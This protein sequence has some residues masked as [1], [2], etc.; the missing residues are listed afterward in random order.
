MG[1]SHMNLR[2][3]TCFSPCWRALIFW[4]FCNKWQRLLSDI[5]RV[6]TILRS[7]KFW[8]LRIWKYFSLSWR[9]L[10]FGIFLRVNGKRLLNDICRVLTVPP[11]SIFWSLC[12]DIQE[13][14]SLQLPLSLGSSSLHPEISNRFTEVSYLISEAMRIVHQPYQLPTTTGDKA[15]LTPF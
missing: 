15:L 10:I 12:S 4:D 2:V 14:P 6:Q 5:L 7:A 1:N 13:L 9:V 11:S 8:S 3:W